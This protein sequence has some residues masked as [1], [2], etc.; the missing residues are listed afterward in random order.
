MTLDVFSFFAVIYLI[1]VEHK[2][3]ILQH[4]ATQ[5]ICGQNRIQVCFPCYV[6]QVIIIITFLLC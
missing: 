3:Q 4:F 2:P 1:E 6:V 5:H